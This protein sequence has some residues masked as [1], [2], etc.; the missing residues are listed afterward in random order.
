[1]DVGIG[2]NYC[3]RR[4]IFMVEGIEK[5]SC[6]WIYPRRFLCPS[7]RNYRRLLHFSLTG[8][9]ERLIHSQSDRVQFTCSH[10][11]LMVW[12]LWSDLRDRLEYLGLN[13]K[14]KIGCQAKFSSGGRL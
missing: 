12:A 14:L 10:K 4:A 1:M 9:P 8:V 7:S 3:C 6:L 11:K 2:G 13:A 5:H